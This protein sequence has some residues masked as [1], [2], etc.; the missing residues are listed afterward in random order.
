M[1]VEF[2]VDTG[3]K[4]ALLSASGPGA[5]VTVS[6]GGATNV[7]LTISLGVVNT[8]LENLSVV[9]VSGLP[10]G[11]VVAGWSFPSS[12]TL[13]LRVFNPTASDV[14]VTAGSVSATVLSKAV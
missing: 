9:S 4:I 8:I 10:D 12:T 2:H 5:D 11:V 1:S 3:H 14:T 13:R 7:D 6:S